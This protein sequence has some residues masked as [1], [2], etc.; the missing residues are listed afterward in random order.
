MPFILCSDVVVYDSYLGTLLECMMLTNEPFTRVNVL[1]RCAACVL[2]IDWFVTCSNMNT[3][4]INIFDFSRNPM[5]WSAFS[6]IPTMSTLFLSAELSFWDV[7]SARDL[8]GWLRSVP[9]TVC[10][11]S[12]GICLFLWIESFI[13]WWAKQW[14]SYQK[15]EKTHDYRFLIL[16]VINWGKFYAFVWLCPVWR[17]W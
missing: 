1:L 8:V 17:T 9:P 5:S 15:N 6:F 14:A 11:G 16:D 4:K 3:R 10:L 12:H 13:Q 7:F 2:C